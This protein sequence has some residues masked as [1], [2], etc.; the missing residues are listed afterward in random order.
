[1][2][3]DVKTPEEYFLQ[4]T[5]GTSSA[6]ESSLTQ[7]E[8][9]F[10]KKYAGLNQAED[11]AVQEPAALLT[12]EPPLPR[13]VQEEAPVSTPALSSSA[14]RTRAAEQKASLQEQLRS[15]EE[16]QLVSFFLCGQEYALPIYMVQEVITFVEPTKLPTAPRFIAGM[17]NLRGRV[18]PLIRVDELLAVSAR[19]EDQERFIVVCRH[20]ALQIGLIVHAVA[21]MYRVRTAEV[22][23]NIET[24]LGVGN[25]HLAGLLKLDEKLIGIIAVDQLVRTVLER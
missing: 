4:Q 13:P 12:P 23:W 6:V 18:T 17:I 3:T 15:T 19:A 7:A 21:T 14:E 1:M 9:A 24:R 8:E 20:D 11:L 22:E 25:Q 2:S 5:F 10:L 16:T